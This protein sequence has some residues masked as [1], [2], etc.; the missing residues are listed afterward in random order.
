MVLLNKLGLG[1]TENT[2]LFRRNLVRWD[3]RRIQK[4]VRIVFK[5]SKKYFSYFMLTKS[6]CKELI[7]VGLS[8]MFIGQRF[9]SFLFGL[10]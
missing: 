9:F 3:E 5:L 2:I 7:I 8:G 6:A 1:E 4:N 10:H